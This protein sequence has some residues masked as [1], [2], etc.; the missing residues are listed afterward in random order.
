MAKRKSAKKIYKAITKYVGDDDR[1]AWYAGISAKPKR[2][3]FT[4]HKVNPGGRWIR[5]RARGE[6]ATRKAEEKLLA[7]GFKGGGG[8]G[9]NPTAVY[10]YRMT[11][12][13]VE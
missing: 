4:D 7:A 10:A 5:K 11:A 9:K 12:T 1:S 13:T 2:R 3:L 8:G 6:D